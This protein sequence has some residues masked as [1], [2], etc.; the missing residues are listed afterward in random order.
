LCFGATESRRQYFAINRC[1]P[2]SQFGRRN[3][4]AAT[5]APHRQMPHHQIKRSISQIMIA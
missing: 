2:K 3:W 4:Y 5:K 1:G